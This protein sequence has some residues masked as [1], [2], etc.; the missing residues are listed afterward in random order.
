MLFSCLK[1]EHGKK[2]GAMDPVPAVQEVGPPQLETAAPLPSAQV[3]R[4][5]KE[6]KSEKFLKEQ[7]SV[8][9]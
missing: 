3:I 6:K 1:P 4:A 8:T 2:H 7:A 9:T 5:F